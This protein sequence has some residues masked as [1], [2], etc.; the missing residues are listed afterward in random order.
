[1]WLTAL[2]C[3]S[4]DNDFRT[5]PV[6]VWEI[7]TVVHRGSSHTLFTLLGWGTLYHIRL[8]SLS[9]SPAERVH[10]LLLQ[11]APFNF[12]PLTIRVSQGAGG[13]E[14]SLFA[15]P[16]CRMEM[17]TASASYKPAHLTL[18]TRERLRKTDRDGDTKI[19][20]ICLPLCQY[21]QFCVHSA[22]CQSCNGLSF[23]GC[24][25]CGITYVY[26]VNV[27]YPTWLNLCIG[28]TRVT[29]I[30]NVFKQR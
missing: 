10:W 29:F 22:I 17:L 23:S 21:L 19:T 25:V 24:P 28:L 1:M 11:V 18:C 27:F 13:W 30:F 9:L 15:F 5:L 12:T 16:G 4:L 8:S 7:R 20:E 14:F 6:E 3:F 26:T 2:R